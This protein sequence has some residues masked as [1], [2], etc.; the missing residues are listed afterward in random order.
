MNTVPLNPDYIA[1]MRGMPH[2]E[3]V[4]LV[5]L[6]TYVASYQ[7]LLPIDIERCCSL[8]GAT[9]RAERDACEHVLAEHFVIT[10]LGRKPLN[11]LFRLPGNVRFAPAEL[12]TLSQ[13]SGNAVGNTEELV[14]LNSNAAK[15]KSYRNRLDNLRDAAL[16]MGLSPPKRT[17]IRELEQ[18]MAEHDDGNAVVTLSSR[19]ALP[20]SRVRAD[21][22]EYQIQG[23]KTERAN[24][25]T[26]DAVTQPGRSL[27][28]GNGSHLATVE[29]ASQYGRAAL[30][31][32]AAGLA[33]VNPSHPKFRALVDAGASQEL[34]DATREL[35]GRSFAYVL[36]TVEGRRREAAARAAIPAKQGSS[37]EDWVGPNV[38]AMMRGQP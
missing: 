6:A 26:H 1:H 36:A 21:L 11:Q 18:L 12:V 2:I 15:Q 13:R 9:T 31:M 16:R 17:S 25:V 28:N 30:A 27:A 34:A 20:P 14:T 3:F 22:P 37:L 4:F 24:T 38:A 35:P 19:S 5:L 7:R 8:I 33:Q 32:K 23:E 29:N 10:E